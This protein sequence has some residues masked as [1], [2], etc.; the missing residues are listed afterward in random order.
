LELLSSK[1]ARLTSGKLTAR[2]PAEAIGFEIL[3][4]QGKVID[5]GTEFGVVSEKGSTEVYVF[6]GKVE[7][8]PAEGNIPGPRMVN[9]TEHQ[10]AL[11]TSG[12]V[13]IRPA[14]AAAAE[15]RF[16]RTITPSPVIVPRTQRLAFDS[17]LA[18]GIKDRSGLH[19][20]LTHRLPGTGKV[21]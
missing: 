1:S 18:S 11:M 4:P 6:E 12:R 16:I 13:T 19:T 17:G 14:L 10:A 21:L 2:V 20:G 15:S 3:S 9:L 5:R 7:A 8:L